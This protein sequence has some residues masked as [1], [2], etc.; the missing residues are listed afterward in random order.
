MKFTKEEKFLARIIVIIMVGFIIRA[1]GLYVQQQTVE[2][3][4]LLSI[5]EDTQEYNISFDGEVHSYKGD[6]E[7]IT[8]K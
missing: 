3:A 8:N 5:N 7:V 4:Q 2:S 6:W 1:Y